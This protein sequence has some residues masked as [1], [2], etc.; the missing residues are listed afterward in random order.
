MQR[1]ITKILRYEEGV[2]PEIYKDHLGLDT[3]G[4]G[5]CLQRIVIPGRIKKIWE[6]E[7]GK[8]LSENYHAWPPMPDRVMDEWLEDILHGNLKLLTAYPEQADVY[9][10]LS[11]CR[12]D[13]LQSMIY[14]LGVKGVLNFKNMWK[15]LKAEDYEKAAKEAM[16]SKWARQT[17]NR[18]QRHAYMIETD[19]YPTEYNC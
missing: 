1:P 13:A 12:Q 5:F 8:E 18:A 17:P 11:N 10:R 2:R 9:S 6:A 4:I 19:R 15:A 7:M 16:D 14:Q 3:I